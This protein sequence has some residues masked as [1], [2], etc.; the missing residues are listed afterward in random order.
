[1]TRIPFAVQKALLKRQR[2][3]AT[4]I[5]LDIRPGDLRRC[6][7]EGTWSR[8]VLVRRVLPTHAIVCLVHSTPEWATE[9]DLVV[10]AGLVR[11]WPI[12]V[13]TQVIGCAGLS[14][15]ETLLTRMPEDWQDHAS[16]G[17]PLG[18]PVND[19]RWAFKAA[20]VD[21]LWALT[22]ATWFELTDDC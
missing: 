20:E 10:P 3:A 15:I 4:Q 7:S 21:A 6:V 8:I 1:M 9:Q 18:S 14:Q 12:I 11:S 2:P 13:Q 5:D 19:A 22:H 16:P 17:L